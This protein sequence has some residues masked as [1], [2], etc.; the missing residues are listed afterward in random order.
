MQSINIDITRLHAS[1]NQAT[2]FNVPMTMVSERRWFEAIKSGV[3]AEQV[4]EVIAYRQKRIIAGVRHPESIFIRGLVGDDERI[5]DFIEEACMLQAKKRHQLKV[6]EP[7]RASVLRVT[8]RSDQV[9]E[10][11]PRTGKEALGQAL[12]ELKRAL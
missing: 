7:A 11:P 6:M 4:A 9:P 8:G 2:G 12:E 5:A 10:Q 3:T 1:F